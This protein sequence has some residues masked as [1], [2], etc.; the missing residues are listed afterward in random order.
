MDSIALESLKQAVE[1]LRDCRAEWIQSVPVDE[2]FQGRPV[3]QGEVD[4]FGLSGHPSADRFY[5]RSEPVE[6]SV[7]R[8]VFAVLHTGPVASALQAVRASIVARGQRS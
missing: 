4:V 5:A 7:T 8:S 1:R 3:W 6:S 2:S